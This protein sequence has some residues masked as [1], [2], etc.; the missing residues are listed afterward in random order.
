MD[1]DE[2]LKRTSD[3]E[4]GSVDIAVYKGNVL[5]GQDELNQTNSSNKWGRMGRYTSSMRN[6]LPMRRGRRAQPSEQ[7]CSKID[8]AG[9]FS[10]VTFAWVSSFL[11]DAYKNRLD[12]RTWTCS[13]F[14]SSSVNMR[15]MERLWEEELRRN[16]SNPS[17]FRV[18]LR[19]IKTR[20]LVACAIFLFCLIFG[21]I[22]PTCLVRGLIAFTEKPARNE[23]NSIDYWYGA[24]LVLSIAVIEF[25]RVLSYGATWAIS[26]RTGIRVRS[27]IL[28]LLFKNLVNV[29][30]LRHKTAAEIVNIYA[31]DGQRLFDAVSFAPLVMM[32]PL[33]LFGGIGYLWMRIGPW[34]WAGILVFFLFDAFQFF[35]GKTMVRCRNAAIEKTEKRVSVMGEILR[36][37]RIIKMNGWEDTFLDRVNGFRVQESRDLKIA[38]YAQSLAIA[39]GPVVPVV[40]AIFTFLGVILTG[41]DLLASDAFSAVTVFFVM[42]FGVRMIPY[43]SRYMAEAVVALRRITALLLLPKVDAAI[44]PPVDPSVALHIQSPQLL[45]DQNDPEEL[46][47]NEKEEENLIS[48]KTN[49]LALTGINLVVKKKELIG[50]CG[51]VGSGKS[52]LLRAAMGHLVDEK[53]ELE[54]AGSVAY[55]SQTPCIQ[56]LSVRDNILFGLEMHN[57]RYQKS[58]K[59][60]HLTKDLESMTS[61]DKT[62]I[63]ERGV[64]L[65]GGQKART[66]LA[67]AL[68][69]NRDLYLLDDVFSALDKKVADAIFEDA[70]LKMLKNKT[71]LMV[72]TDVKRLSKCDRVIYMENGTIAGIDAHKALL[73]SVTA[74]QS[75]CETSRTMDSD[76]EMNKSTLEEN[77]KNPA[78]KD[79]LVVAADISRDRSDTIVSAAK[80]MEDV[81]TAGKVIE[82]EEDFGTAELSWRVY[83]KYITAAGGM[84]MWTILL[85]AFVVNVITSIFS[86]YWLSRWLKDG[87]I[88][89]IVNIDGFNVTQQ[90]SLADNENNGFYAGIYILSVFLLFGS[91]LMKAMIIVRAT[92]NAGTNLHKNMLNSV[93]KGVVSFFDA[94]PTGRILNRFS[95]DMDEIDVKLPFTAEVF[96]QNMITCVGFLLMI[97]YIFPAFLI[98]AIPLIVVFVLCVKCFRAGIRCLKRSEN[99]SRSPLF[100]HISSTMD[101]LVTI[102]AYGQSDRFLDTLKTRLDENS[103]SMFMFQSAMRWLAVWLDL[104]VVCIT[105]G[106]SACMVML[107][108]RVAPADAGMALAFAIQMSGI[109]QF[110]VRTQ[111]ELEAK[112]T[113]VERVA[114]YAENV[115][116]EKDLDS[117]SQSV[118]S[119]WPQNGAVEFKDVKLRYRL[120]LPL[121]LDNVSF[122]VKPKEKIGIVGR[123]GSGKSSLC[124]ALYRLYPLS[125][126][127]IKI[128]HVDTSTVA[129]HRLRKAM[130]VIPQDPSLFAGTVRFNLDPAGL[131]SDERLWSALERTYLKDTVAGLDGKLDYVIGE[132]GRNLSVGERQLMCMTRALLTEV[133]IVV[134]DEATASLDVATDRL[135]QK[136]LKE[137]FENCTVLL[138]AHRLENVMGMDKIIFMNH[139]KMIEFD[140]TKNLM[141]KKES[142][143][144]QLVT[145]HQIEVDPDVEVVDEVKTPSDDMSA[146]S[147][148][149]ETPFEHVDDERRDE[150]IDF[151]DEASAKESYEVVGEKSESQASEPKGS[152]ED[153]DDLERVDSLENIE[154]IEV[155]ESE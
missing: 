19:F 81:S 137:A 65:S 141:A 34:A 86:T 143:F 5:S 33:V 132:G 74:Y 69:S 144:R 10:F 142:S 6:M 125:W 124:N 113:S 88:E 35:L 84:L 149:A 55:V 128:D 63:G 105:F 36:C 134:L 43:G 150:K 8:E 110:A 111:T 94:T 136:C 39:S 130:A 54:M 56:N 135:I 14:D 38:G 147:T 90:R 60:A 37:I 50:I 70:V 68:F 7:N 17:L 71:V 2:S 44:P 154:K 100:D 24:S 15:R 95:K 152:S 106:V 22:G 126:G 20:L 78:P 64:T 138:I 133:K 49:N 127:H 11:W 79:F 93:V 61:S 27:A 131:F 109:F 18:L 31:N 12:E 87:H 73:E 83:L 155:E 82:D 21:F 53:G 51:P 40:A 153:N 92:L 66:A 47:P 3:S 1:L 119:D 25:A 28:T 13:I 77:R 29:R 139:G 108:G 114:Y 30:T 115:E 45:W 67:R 96:L 4:R 89:E 42:L 102:N 76:D 145:G 46:K 101:G 23:D 26:Y 58:I 118:P 123:T 48:N 140:S 41:N 80:S 107:T 99:N 112:M 151:D 97:A 104:L 62:E 116:Q 85:V 103:G 52:A 57:N 9:L 120:N 121:A 72:T 16:P 117:S 122:E 98:F 32:G 91:G 129:L 148:P 75:F 59:S 146:L